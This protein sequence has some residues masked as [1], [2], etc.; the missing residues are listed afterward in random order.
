MI[1]HLPDILDHGEPVRLFPV[2]ADTSREQRILSIFLAV[3]TQVP[4]FAHEILGTIGVRVGKRTKI[5]AFTEVTLKTKVEDAGRPD[6]LIIATSGRNTWTALIEAKI[7]KSNLDVA[8]V[9][10][11]LKLAR[12]NGIQAVI[13]VSNDFA[14]RPDHSPV[15]GSTPN[16]KKLSRNVALYHWSWASLATCCDVLAYQGLHQSPE[17]VFLVNQLSLYFKHPTTGIERF[18]Q[19]GPQWK[20]I[21]QLVSS[22]VPLAKNTPGLEEVVAS[23]FAEERDLSLHMTSDLNRPV[24]L[25][26]D[27]KHEGKAKHRLEDGV[28]ALIKTQALT[29]TIRVP[30]CASDINVRADLTRRNI[31]VSMTI[32]ARADRKTPRARIKWLLGMLKTDDPRLR[33]TAYWPGRA[34]ATSADISVLRENPTILQPDNTSLLPQ[35]FEVVLVEDPGG[36]RFT[37]QKAFIEDLERV[38]PEFYRLVGATLKTWHPSPPQPIQD[39]GPSDNTAAEIAGEPVAESNES[40]VNED[41]LGGCDFRMVTCLP[42]IY[43]IL[44]I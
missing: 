30:D 9:E 35:S 15:A 4:D 37:G 13:T 7:G 16:I 11:Y 1:T 23:W 33:V 32:R 29:S 14:A 17:Q 34:A 44:L 28:A 27:R 6:A 12:D 38:V 21:V 39:A 25:K 10:R 8:Q 31:S 18:T 40:F 2:V 20:D 42:P 41:T 36:K 43:H 19:M 26:I 22:G 5:T 3:L 24:R